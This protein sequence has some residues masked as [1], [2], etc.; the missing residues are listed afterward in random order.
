MARKHR[1]RIQAQGDGTEKSTNWSQDE[2]LSK[3]DGLSLLNKLWNSLSK[4]E[5][6]DRCKQFDSARRFIENVEGG[7]DAPLG[8]TFLNRKKRSVRV[9]IEVLAGTAFLIV[10]LLYFFC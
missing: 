4:R 7:V 3:E 10:I 2:P 1:G 9:D 6:K 5:Q 8:K